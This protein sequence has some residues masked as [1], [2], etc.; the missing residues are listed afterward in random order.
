MKIFV[1]LFSGDELVSDT[2][3]MKTVD[4]CILEFT[5][6]YETRKH[7]EVVLPGSNAS[8]EEAEADEGVDE[9]SESG[10]DIVLNH[11]LQD[12]AVYQDLKV[13]K[14]YIKEYMGKLA[15]R[16]KE[17]GSNDDEVK[18]FKTAMQ[19]WV[20]ELIKKERFKNLAFYSGPGESAHEGQLG[21]LEYRDFDGV[22]K[23]IFMFIKQGLREEKC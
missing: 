5:G 16:M 3:P 11:K 2:Y 22:E 10:I 1:D 4:N 20:V 14:E 13:F 23:P 18:A 15:K 12:M 7:G 6:K 21:I 17:D 9:F 19:S 8:A